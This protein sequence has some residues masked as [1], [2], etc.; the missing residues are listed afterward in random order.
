MNEPILRCVGVTKAFAGVSAV[1]DI[2]LALEHGEVL[3]I[4]GP[5]G[6]GKTTLLRM[7][8][9]FEVPD[10]GEIEVASRLVSGAGVE[11]PP[12][13]RRIGMVFQD[14]ALFPHLTVA[15][16]AAFGLR[17]LSAGERDRRLAD[18]LE[19]VRL[20]GLEGRYPFELSGG[21]QQR[22]ALART[23]APR[24]AAVLLDEP[25][26][27]LDAEMRREMRAEV[28]AILRENGIATL[29]VTHDRDEAFAM[30]DRMAVMNEGRLDQVDRPDVIY[31]APATRFVAQLAGSCDFLAASV[32]G[33]Q[34]VS[35]IGILACTGSN[36]VPDGHVVDLMVHPDDFQVLPNPDGNCVVRS[37]E[38][39]G[40]ETTLVVALPSGAALRCSQ[41]SY[42]LL[43]AGDRVT[44]VPQN[45]A[46]FVAFERP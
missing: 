40:D 35:E 10:A 20:S 11:V 22:V 7:I 13:R 4:L 33:A 18:V 27:N 2:S 42:P 8:A 29:F 44:L 23:L 30:A 9:G 39:R 12:E 15:E 41:H 21:Q 32:N 25:F 24:P 17:D 1:D 36:G 14:Y 28:Q 37:R 5:S 31:S 46:P 26:S 16:N 34:A 45:G 19:L 3:S 43:V 6:C 38:F